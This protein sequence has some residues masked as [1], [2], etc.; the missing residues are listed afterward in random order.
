M[1]YE[2]AGVDVVK[3]DLFVKGISELVRS[4]YDENVKAGV[5]GFAA[6]YDIGDRYLVSGTDGVGTKLMLARELDDH[7]SIGQDLVAMCV[8]DILCTGASPLFFLDYL[9]TGKLTPEIHHDV[10]K[11]IAIACKE[12]HCALIGG[13][14]AEMPGC[15]AGADYDLA[16]FAVGMVDKNKVIDGSQVKPGMKILGLP[17]SGFHS[18]GY[19]LV[20]HLLEGEST[21]LKTQCLAPTKLYTSDIKKILS[22]EHVYGLAHI[23]GGG[24][25]NISRINEE[26]SYRIDSLPE[27]PDFMQ[28]LCDKSALEA[29]ELY[30]TFNMG[31]GF[32]IVTSSPSE[33]QSLL[34]QAQLIGEVQEGQG[35]SCQG[36]KI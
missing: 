35:V 30:R 33:I 36:I 4:T 2:Q 27:M 3:G 24:L 18:N 9:A 11:G 31:L 19:S 28:Y 15:Y 21:E 5:G 7:T 8:N 34:P 14:T 29:K 10:V 13:E 1:N 17:S 22:T 23:T 32:C 6:L 25:N 20:R 26:F 16:G 12:A